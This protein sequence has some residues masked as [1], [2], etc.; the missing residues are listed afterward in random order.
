MN[1]S[2][3]HELLGAAFGNKTVAAAEMLNNMK[4]EKRPT[5]PGR[6]GTNLAIVHGRAVLEAKDLMRL[7]NTSSLCTSA[8]PSEGPSDGTLLKPSLDTSS[9]SSHEPSHTP[10]GTSLYEQNSTSHSTSYDTC[11]I[12][13]SVSNLTRRQGAVLYYL[14]GRPGFIAQRQQISAATGIPLPTIRDNIVCLTNENFITKPIKYVHKSFQGFTYTVNEELCNRFLV[15]RGFEFDGSS[16]SLGTSVSTSHRTSYHPAHR[17]SVGTSDEASDGTSDI[18]ARDYMPLEEG[19]ALSLTSSKTDVP[20]LARRQTAHL[21]DREADR[22]TGGETVG[23]VLADPEH[24]YWKDLGL[25]EK[26]LTTWMKETEMDANEMGLSLRY[27]RF[28]FLKDP[29]KVKSPLD[30]FYTTI[31]RDGFFPKP[32]DYKSLRQIR[33]DRSTAEREA[34]SHEDLQEERLERELAFNQ[35]FQDKQSPEFLLLKAEVGKA[36]GLQLSGKFLETAM[37]DKFMQSQ[38]SKTD[39]ERLFST[40]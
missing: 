31:K 28:A 13:D 23:A 8:G 38:A 18:R 20:E 27:A 26:K 24:L 35:I 39:L 17:P 29:A 40:R 7:D 11:D 1:K 6:P 16:P 22:M 21:T 32:V 9:N 37:R 36:G 33:I 3:L 12:F 34:R 14:L 25:T 5:V 30:Y 15:Q 19:K 10:S 2:P 4:I